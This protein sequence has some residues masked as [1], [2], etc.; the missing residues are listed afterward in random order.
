METI[1][2]IGFSATELN[3]SDE[4]ENE[5]FNDSDDNESSVN[6]D[7]EIVQI[8]ENKRNFLKFFTIMPGLVRTFKIVLGFELLLIIFSVIVAVRSR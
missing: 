7:E 8:S 1:G 3:K 2:E 5:N 6:E 4:S